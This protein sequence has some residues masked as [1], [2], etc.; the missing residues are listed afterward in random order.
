MAAV[1]R[2]LVGGANQLRACPSSAGEGGGE[3]EVCLTN[4]EVSVVT[5]P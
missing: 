4:M 3:A 2:V 5:S 1:R